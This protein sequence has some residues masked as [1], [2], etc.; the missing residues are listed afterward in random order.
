[1]IRMFEEETV[2]I[3]E[4]SGIINCNEKYTKNKK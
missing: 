2:I 4:K 1:M 3:S